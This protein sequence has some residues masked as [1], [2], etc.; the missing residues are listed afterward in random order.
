MIHLI[1]KEVTNINAYDDSKH[2]CWVYFV[3]QDDGDN[4][5]KSSIID[6]A[7]EGS[8]CSLDP[9]WIKENCRISLLFN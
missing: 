3:R 9:K 4:L 1:F 6:N 2:F 5:D 8:V 7:S